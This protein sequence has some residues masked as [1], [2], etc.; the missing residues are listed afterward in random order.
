MWHAWERS[1]QDFGGKDRGV[2]GRGDQNG[3]W[4]GVEWLSIG[5]DGGLL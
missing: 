3:S 4:L 1:V 2:H 5:A